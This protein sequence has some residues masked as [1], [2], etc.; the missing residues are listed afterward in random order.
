M[1]SELFCFTS[2]IS[3]NPARVKL[4]LLQPLPANKPSV[5]FILCSGFINHSKGP[6][7]VS[8][9]TFMF[10]LSFSVTVDL[11]QDG[12]TTVD[13]RRRNLSKQTEAFVRHCV[14]IQTACCH[15]TLR[16]NVTHPYIKHAVKT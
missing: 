12:S 5:T 15:S 4:N 13:L 11:L 7:N 10:L 2:V 8:E 3:F 14:R 9:A 16:G 1:I 6:D